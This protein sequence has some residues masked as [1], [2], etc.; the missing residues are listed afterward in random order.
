MAHQEEAPPR[1]RLMS[2][3]STPKRVRAGRRC[4]AGGIDGPLGSH[5]AHPCSRIAGGSTPHE[6]V[7]FA[8]D[9]PGRGP[10]HRPEAEGLKDADP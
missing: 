3:P 8:A 5:P 1:L 2:D 6:R 9:L 7:R 4:A 10:E